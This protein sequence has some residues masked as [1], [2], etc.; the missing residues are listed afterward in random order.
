MSLLNQFVLGSTC[1]QD[2]EWAKRSA[3]CSISQRRMQFMCI[4][5]CIWPIKYKL[6]NTIFNLKYIFKIHVSEILPI[7]AHMP[8]H[9]QTHIL[10]LDM[11]PVL[12]PVPAESCLRVPCP[13]AV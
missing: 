6:Q 1:P 13:T 8:T 11:L 10:S 3:H 4:L 12:L 2:Y 7:P 5:F 9:T